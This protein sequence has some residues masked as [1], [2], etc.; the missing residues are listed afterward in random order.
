MAAASQSSRRLARLVASRPASSRAAHPGLRVVRPSCALQ[1]CLVQRLGDVSQ[2]GEPPLAADLTEQPLLRSLRHGVRFAEAGDPAFTS[3]LT[4]D[5]A[6]A[7]CP[8]GPVGR[9]RSISRA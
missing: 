1:R 8:R 5:E 6:A 9:A 7:S 2:V 4:H 3:T